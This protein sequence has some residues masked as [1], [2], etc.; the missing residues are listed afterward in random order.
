M[1]RWRQTLWSTKYAAL[2]VLAILIV[3]ARAAQAEV[4]LAKVFTDHMVLQRQM[5]IRIWGW[6]KAQEHLSASF[7]GET[8]EAVADDKGRWEVYFQP[9]EAGGPFTLEVSGTNKLHLD[10]ILVG[11][12]WIA[13]GQSNMEMPLSGWGPL[14]P[15]KDSAKEIAAA[16][17]PTMRFLT[18]AETSSTFP[19]DDMQTSSKWRVC[20]PEVAG[21]FSAV[22]YFF[23]RGLIEREKVPVGIIVA[24]WGGTPIEA[25]TSIRALSAEP[26][27]LPT[28]AF[29]DVMNRRRSLDLRTIAA[30]TA[31]DNALRAAGKEPPAR[32][33]RREVLSWQ[34][35]ALFNGMI[36]PLTPLAVKGVIWYQ[37][38]SNTDHDRAP[39]YARALPAMISD[40]RREWRE[41]NLPFLYVQI[42]AFGLEPPSP[43]SV[44]REA[45]R[46]TLQVA[47]TAMA[48]SADA[49]D[50]KNVHPADKQTVGHRLALAARAVAYGEPIEFSGPS[51]RFIASSNGTMRV[52]FDHADGLR[53]TDDNVAGFEVA[54]A[55][56]KFVSASAR[57]TGDSVV[58]SSASVEH[59]EYIRYA[60]IPASQM[61]LYNLAGLPAS[62]FTSEDDYDKRESMLH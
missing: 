38:E 30:E 56:R 11:D 51:V 5:P 35:G 26:S 53:A 21:S 46:R 10:D 7:R 22:A 2:A 45:Q 37:G 44:V 1:V 8:Q 62:P 3:F 32:K 41:P 42:S 24:A 58:V 59:P 52:W 29:S 54:G 36:A 18:V 40:W 33:D 17:H 19:L 6:A 13:A 12:I 43:W 49:G 50:L 31:E 57:I 55:D 60:W 47:H 39:L 27:L 23:A 20:T 28:L 25:W 61:S 14:T 16:N 34:P 15:I 9:S 48:V 4:E